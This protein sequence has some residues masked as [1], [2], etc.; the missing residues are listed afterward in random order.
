[1][2][3]G[4]IV[5]ALWGEGKDSDFPIPPYESTLKAIAGTVKARTYQHEKNVIYAYGHDNQTFLQQQ[6]LASVLISA[7]PIV[8]WDNAEQRNPSDGNR[9]QW[10]LSMWR[11]KLDAIHHALYQAEAVIWLDWDCRQVAPLPLDFWEKLAAGPPFRASLR[12]YLG[13]QAGW[14]TIRPDKRLVPHGAW[15]YYRRENTTDTIGDVIAAHKT[16]YPTKTDE[17]AVAKYLDLLHGGWIGEEQWKATYEPDCYDQGREWRQ[18][19]L[20]DGPV[21]F[22]NIGRY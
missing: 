13:V 10:G 19:F 18:V 20:C 12:S 5:R 22:K 7:D 9:V 6:G 2:Q 11:H 17:T 8:N 14:R 16:H 21:L 15:Q 1:M 3:D 4:L